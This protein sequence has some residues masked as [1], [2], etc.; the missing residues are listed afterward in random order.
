MNMNLCT[1]IQ[2]DL[3]KWQF[4]PP[5]SK[6]QIRKLR[7]AIELEQDKKQKVGMMLKLQFRLLVDDLKEKEFSEPASPKLPKFNHKKGS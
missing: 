2:S 6:S 3:K 1:S 5:L 4:L 7:Q